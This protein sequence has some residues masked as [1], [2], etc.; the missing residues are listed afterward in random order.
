ML[1]PTSSTSCT[2]R[3]QVGYTV[4]YYRDSVEA[5][6]LLG[7]VAGSGVLGSDIPYEVGPFA[8]VGYD[9]ANAATSG[10]TLVTA[11]ASANVLNVV[12]T[13]QSN[14]S[15]RVNYYLGSM[16]GAPVASETATAPTAMRSPSRRASTS[17][18]ATR[19]P[20]R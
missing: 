18:L 12:Y 1:T 2:P 19:P 5:A 15:W 8:P 16:D 14:L 7:S 9:V 3:G 20:P 6:N 10:Q 13:K 17:P 11:D 4:N